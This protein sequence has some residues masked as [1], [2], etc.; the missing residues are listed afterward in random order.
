MRFNGMEIHIHLV[1]DTR[2]ARAS[3]LTYRKDF[4]DELILASFGIWIKSVS[5]ELIKFVD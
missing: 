1:N 2:F 4:C 5:K 3:S